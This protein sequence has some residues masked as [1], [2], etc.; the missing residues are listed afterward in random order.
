[1]KIDALFKKNH[2]SNQTF[3]DEEKN[4]HR[5]IQRVVCEHVWPKTK[6]LK[7]EG[8]FV[9]KSTRFGRKVREKRQR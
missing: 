5:E 6:F 8:H 4:V 9:K 7:G 3:K 1:M 2:D